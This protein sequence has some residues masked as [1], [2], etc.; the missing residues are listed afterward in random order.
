MHEAPVIAS[1]AEQFLGLNNE[2][3]ASE[4]MDEN[5]SV[6]GHFRKGD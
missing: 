1:Q 3:L 6:K 5:G 4:G 2:F